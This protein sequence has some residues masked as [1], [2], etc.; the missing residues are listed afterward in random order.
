[1]SKPISIYISK[2]TYS[3]IKNIYENTLCNLFNLW[4]NITGQKKGFLLLEFNPATYQQFLMSL[5]KTNKPII[6]L[7]RRRSAIWNKESLK[8]IKK[9]NRTRKT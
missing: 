6:L 2:K 4:F 9:C 1:M 8:I 7:N 5:D 3:K